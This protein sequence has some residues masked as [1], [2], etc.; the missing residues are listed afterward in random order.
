MHRSWCACAAIRIH[1]HASAATREARAPLARYSLVM[2]GLRSVNGKNRMRICLP[3]PLGHNVAERGQATTS[4]VFRSAVQHFAAGVERQRTRL[5][6][7]H[8]V[9]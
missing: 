6:D 5:S 2:S 9:Q 7:P 4:M 1:L 8:T 3:T